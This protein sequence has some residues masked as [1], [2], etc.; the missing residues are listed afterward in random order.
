[1]DFYE[2]YFTKIKS[3]FMQNIIRK[4]L[5]KFLQKYLRNKLVKYHPNTQ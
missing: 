2:K 3:F 1:M 5:C 4:N